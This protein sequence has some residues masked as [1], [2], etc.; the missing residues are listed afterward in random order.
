MTWGIFSQEDIKLD[1]EEIKQIRLGFRF[2]MNEG[3]ISENHDYNRIK[4]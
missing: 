1:P 4:K 3:V 2:M